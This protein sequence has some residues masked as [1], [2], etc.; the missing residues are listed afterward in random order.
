[1][2][3]GGAE[4]EGVGGDTVKWRWCE[5]LCRTGGLHQG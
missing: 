5:S 4:G 2:G 3:G 1:M